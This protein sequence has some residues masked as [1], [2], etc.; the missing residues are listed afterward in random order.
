MFFQLTIAIIAGI[1]AGIFTGL[2]PGLH[3]N[4]VSLI[5]VSLSSSFFLEINV[6]L[7]VVFIVSLALTHSF[8]DSI[9]SIF[10]GAPD[11]SQVLSVLPG[12]RF[13][14][15]GLGYQAVFLTIVGS[16]TALLLTFL[17]IPP[18]LILLSKTYIILK[19]IV[20]F[21]LIIVIIILLILSKKIIL[22]TLFIMLSGILGLLVFSLPNQENILLPLLT[23]LFGISTL[24]ISFFGE[25]NS[26]PKQDT[27]KKI[28][29]SIS[30]LEK[31]SFRATIVGVL[32]AFLPGLGSSQ[33]AIIASATMKKKT[34][35]DYLLLVGGINTVNF[36]FS[37]ITLFVIGKARNG[38][39][40]S[41]NTLL[42]DGLTSYHLKSLLL[43]LLIVGS[44]ASLLGLWISK[45]V[46]NI[47]NKVNYKKL[48]LFIMSF[49]FL[50][51]LFMTGPT[52]LLILFTASALGLL[53][54]LVGAQKNMLLGVLLIPTIIFLL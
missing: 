18:G 10:L 53:A 8:L 30:E 13:L 45:K 32:A 48:L 42:Q 33:S 39:I 16:L 36:A 23:G 9:P 5:V 4:L 40:V 54:N 44:V 35:K 2:I 41:V 29:V 37:L 47:I 6:F 19:P 21:L 49:L 24:L 43:T 14:L 46:S 12:H 25:M 11:E 51:V 28:D 38:A 50:I 31:N 1:I 15:Q 34:D 17:V 22:N 3:V 26:L 52:G 20:P 27:K 7:L